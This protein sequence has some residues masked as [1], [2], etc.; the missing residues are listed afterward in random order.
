MANSA[1]FLGIKFATLSTLN[2]KL[3][4]IVL[5]IFLWLSMFGLRQKSI[6]V[7]YRRFKIFES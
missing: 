7:H 4:A 6:L 3:F 2:N 1:I 5:F